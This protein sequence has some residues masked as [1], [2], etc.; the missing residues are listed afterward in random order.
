[1]TLIR[2]NRLEDGTTNLAKG[3]WAASPRN[4][5][6]R[7]WKVMSMTKVIFRQHPHPPGYEPGELPQDTMK[8]KSD[9]P[10]RHR[11]ARGK[12]TIENTPGRR[13]V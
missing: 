3:R 6:D 9:L 5:P 8:A 10:A 12:P 13:V 2:G 1:M 4:D 11:T 7:V